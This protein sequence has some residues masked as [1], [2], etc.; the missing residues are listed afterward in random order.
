MIRTVFPWIK[1]LDSLW[2]KEYINESFIIQY[3]SGP[4]FNW[5][6]GGGG[7]GGLG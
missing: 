6:G 1:L 3:V 5:V 7:G 4:V 2:K